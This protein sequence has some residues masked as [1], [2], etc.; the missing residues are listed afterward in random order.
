MK[1]LTAFESGALAC[2]ID[3]LVYK[4]AADA[5]GCTAHAIKKALHR[6]RVKFGARTNCHLVAMVAGL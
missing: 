6:A 4:Q 2:M 1:P 3:G 5:M